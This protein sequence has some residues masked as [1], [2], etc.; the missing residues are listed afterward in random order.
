M[1]LRDFLP[2]IVRKVYRTVRR[3]RAETNHTYSSFQ[4][5][6]RACGKGYEEEELTRVVL[7]KTLAYKKSLEVA[8]HAT[9]SATEAFGMLSMAHLLTHSEAASRRI[10]V[11]DLGGACGAHY[12]AFKRF[13]GDR[14]RFRWLVVETPT[15]CRLAEPLRNDE[16]AFFDS[17][18]A[19]LR[20]GENPDLLHVS[21]VLQFVEHPYVMLDLLVKSGAPYLF[22]NRM[23]FTAKANDVIGVRRSMLSANGIG[24]L[25][26]GIRDGEVSYPYVVLARRKFDSFLDSYETVVQ[27]ED[28]TGLSPIKDEPLQATGM[29]LRRKRP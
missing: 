27:F 12:F 8:S 22:F 14:I 13:F 5:A 23:A 3:G 16:L 7:G 10:T 20:S 17:L 4:E 26:P 24:P 9:V 25:P 19:A 1:H 2:P 21:G 11:L 15:M 6:L 28:N 18:P 29:L